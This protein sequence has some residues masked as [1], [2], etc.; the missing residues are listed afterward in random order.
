MRLLVLPRYARNG[1]SS[2]VRHYQFVEH[3]NAAGFVVDI[4][5]LL[6]DEYL[7]VL[8]RGKRWSYWQSLFVVFNRLRTIA[9]SG[10]YDLVWV[11]KEVLPFLPAWPEQFLAWR[12]V[13]L[14]AD[15]DD[16]WHLRYHQLR[17]PLL[18]H[19]LRRKVELVMRSATL[20]TVGNSY[21]EQVAK[22]SGASR[23]VELP[24]VLDVS[25]Y[26]I[27]HHRERSPVQIVWI[28]SSLNSRYLLSIADA[29][30]YVC[31]AHGA[32]LIVVGGRP[33]RLP[34]VP[35][36]FEPWSERTE[37]DVL[38]AADLG[39][40]PLDDTDWERG[41]CAYK[42][43]QYMAAGLPVVASPV[44]VNSKVVSNDVGLL[45]TTPGEWIE[46]LSRL[47][48]D[49]GLRGQMGRAGR[50][51]VESEFSLDAW[52]PR[53]ADLLTDA[54]NTARPRS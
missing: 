12:G 33:V 43:L 46:A 11:E 7:D 21:L 52:G 19:F 32:E 2:R 34:D 35:V 31:K 13:C 8:Y 25:R 17:S 51:K 49:P 23:I 29:L 10:G 20:V 28:G 14:V 40:M 24:S 6:P 15:F 5:P 26:H 47:I 18:R 53:L 50:S 39:I 54:A 9:K 3:L 27:A 44:G 36:R 38:A 41:K 37:A 22:E 48:R 1:P 16:A 30:A 4:A 42:I 45:A